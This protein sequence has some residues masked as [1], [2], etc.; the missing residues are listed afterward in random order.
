[1]IPFNPI[2][3]PQKR[4]KFSLGEKLAACL[5]HM[6]RDD[7]TPLVP[8]AEGMT[9][10]EICA[11]VEFDHFQALELLGSNHPSNI[12]PLPVKKH[13]TEKTPADAKKIAKARHNRKRELRH[14]EIMT[15]KIT[16]EDTPRDVKRHRISSRPFDKRHRPMPKSRGFEKRRDASDRKASP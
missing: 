5:C 1:M 11:A 3:E 10:K 2:P 6:T 4:K 15:A 16:G 13:R 9:V 12:V 8:G 14:R 7:G